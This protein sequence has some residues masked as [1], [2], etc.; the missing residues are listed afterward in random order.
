MTWDPECNTDAH[1]AGEHLAVDGHAFAQRRLEPVGECF[2]AVGIHRVRGDHHELVAAQPG[3]QV[4]S[5]GASAEP[6]GEHPDEPVARGVAEVVVDGF[7]PVEVEEQRRDRAGAAFRQPL[8]EVCQQGPTVVQPCQIVV[9]GEV[10]QLLLGLDPRLDLCEQRRDRLEG[11]EFLLAP[12]PVAELDESECA[13]GDLAGDQGGRRHRGGRHRAAFLDP[14]L[15]V[16]GGRFGTQHDR[17][18]GVLRH[19]EH[20]VGVGEEHQPEGVWVGGIGADRPFGDQ[21]GRAQRVV[22]VAQEAD[23]DA[24]ECDQVTQHP[25]AHLD[26]RDGSRRHQLGGHRRDH[27]VEA[28]GSG[29]LRH[30]AVTIR[31]VRHSRGGDHSDIGSRGRKSHPSLRSQGAHMSQRGVTAQRVFPRSGQRLVQ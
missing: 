26:R 16:V 25:L 10:A 4:G 9:F 28:A 11:V 19:G 30:R 7:E 17:L 23:V 3:D 24:E 8:V 29:V 13:G 21:S 18:L 27:Q 2:G 1:G 12:L 6:F 20:R 31:S 15:V 14:A 22:V 5:V